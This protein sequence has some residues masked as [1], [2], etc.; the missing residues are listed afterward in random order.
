MRKQVRQKLIREILQKFEI[1]KQD[2]IVQLLLNQG[3][4]VTQATISRDVKEMQLIKLP[5]KNGSY[6]Y[7]VPT[8]K[9]IDVQKKLK[10][11][12]SESYVSSNIA[13]K[14]IFFKVIPGSGPAVSNLIEKV[15]YKEVFATL[16]DDSSVM[17]FAYSNQEAID[18]FEKLLELIGVQ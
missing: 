2:D 18:L 11:T 8:L 17:V 9:E 6:R 3:I 14:M 5:T 12:L 1:Y 15:G 7:S 16:S 13:E 10:D 4:E